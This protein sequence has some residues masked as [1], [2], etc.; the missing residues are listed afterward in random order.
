MPTFEDVEEALRLKRRKNDPDFYLID[1]ATRRLLFRIAWPRGTVETSIVGDYPHRV[2]FAV[3]P[4][5]VLQ[6]LAEEDAMPDT[7]D[8][9]V[10]QI[11]RFIGVIEDRMY[12][13]VMGD[14]YE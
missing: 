4:S 9:Y 7:F 5:A 3:W 11:K 1:K 8:L 12:R 14:W 6:R 13:L 2:L 10:S